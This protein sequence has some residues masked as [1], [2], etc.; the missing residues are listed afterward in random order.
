MI[1]FSIPI[2]QRNIHCY[3]L[4]FFLL[5]VTCSNEMGRLAKKTK[6]ELVTPLERICINLSNG[7]KITDISHTQPKLL[8]PE[9]A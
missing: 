1:T 7:V 3:H 8:D 4:R 9:H 5:Y 6:I 2:S